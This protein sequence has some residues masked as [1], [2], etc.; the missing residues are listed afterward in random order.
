MLTLQLGLRDFVVA[1]RTRR[2]RLGVVI[3]LNW[4]SSD[5]LDLLFELG[6]DLVNVFRSDEDAGP[7]VSSLLES[8]LCTLGD[9][10]GQDLSGGSRELTNVVAD[11]NHQSGGEDVIVHLN[12]SLD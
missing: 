5:T 3:C 11:P 12:E 6:V 7:L 4:L 1:E 2:H 8:S 9:A 10:S